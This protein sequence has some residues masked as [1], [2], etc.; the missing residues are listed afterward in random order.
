MKHGGMRFLSMILIAVLLLGGCG[1]KE[2]PEVPSTTEQETTTKEET[3]TL[4]EFPTEEEAERR[5]ANRFKADLSKETGID[6]DLT[7][8]N[9]TM[10]YAQVNDMMV[11]PENYIGKKVKMTGTYV[12]FFDDTTGKRYYSCIIKDALACCA[13]GI[14]FIP[15]DAFTYPADYPLE[16]DVVTVI[17]IFDTYLEDGYRY[18]T[19]RDAVFDFTI[20]GA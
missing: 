7:V 19:L 15:T 9:A 3:T 5:N 18:V 10:T 4:F 1:K 12:E 20:G 8:L 14:E 6:V 2:E 11:T 16:E 17:G 13:Q